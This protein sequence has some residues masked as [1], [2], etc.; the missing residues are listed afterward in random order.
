MKKNNLRAKPA[1]RV[2]LRQIARMTVQRESPAAIKKAWKSYI[3]SSTSGLTMP[4]ALDKFSV[5]W[6]GFQESLNSQQAGMAKELQAK[7]ER[8][9]SHEADRKK[10]AREME[11]VRAAYDKRMKVLQAK[12]D[13]IG[14]DAQLANVDLQNALQK[15]QQTLQMISTIS[16][17]LNDT[18]MAVIRKIRA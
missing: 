6:A 7:R 14:D 10:I 1:P 11:A 8:V 2:Q 5:I 3:E 4:E 16:K 9:K 13:A 15:Q 12:L 18:A 17:S